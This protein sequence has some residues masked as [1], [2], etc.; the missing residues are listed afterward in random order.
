[1][2]GAEAKSGS[3]ERVKSCKLKAST[4]AVVMGR[5]LLVNGSYHR[6]RIG[7]IRGTMKFKMDNSVRN[8]GSAGRKKR[9]IESMWSSRVSK[10]GNSSRK[11]DPVPASSR[12]YFP[13]CVELHLNS[14][15][16]PFR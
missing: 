3:F 11:V 10:L 9:I 14:T 15:V 5:H 1:M 7:R 16:G 2:V 12:G 6:P 8:G 13:E 4:G